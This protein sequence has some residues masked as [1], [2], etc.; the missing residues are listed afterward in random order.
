[1]TLNGWVYGAS[2]KE[3]S[4]AKRYLRV[5]DRK[6]LPESML[7]ITWGSIADLAIG[8]VQDFL[9]EPA[10]A[11]DEYAVNCVRQLAVSHHRQA[12]QPQAFQ[13]NLSVK[14]IV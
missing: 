1:M 12:V 8:Q 10:N 14:R 9:Q 4:F 7:R 5:R 11:P 3:I 6:D 13:E 2:D